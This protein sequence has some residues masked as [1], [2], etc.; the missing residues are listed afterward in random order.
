MILDLASAFHLVENLGVFARDWTLSLIDR[1]SNASALRRRL[2]VFFD[3]GGRAR[4]RPHALR[5]YAETAT[6][7]ACHRSVL[8]ERFGADPSSSRVV[9]LHDDIE[10]RALHQLSRMPAAFDFPAW[11]LALASGPP[12]CA[13]SGRAG[14]DASGFF[15]GSPGVL[16]SG[17]CAIVSP[18]QAAMESCGHRAGPRRSATAPPQCAG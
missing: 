2:L 11:R 16:P 18:A 9:R 14:D 8:R 13:H 1:I 7:T 10:G 6:S 3:F 4:A 12:T 17:A 5:P 15:A